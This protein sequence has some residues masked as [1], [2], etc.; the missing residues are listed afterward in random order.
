MITARDEDDD[1]DYD[2]A[3]VGAE[4]LVGV[5]V[6][7]GDMFAKVRSA[8]FESSCRCVNHGGRMYTAVCIILRVVFNLLLCGNYLLGVLR[9]SMLT[10]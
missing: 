8:S 2:E 10:I 9:R 7:K 5:A 6:G 4:A 3:G 1:G